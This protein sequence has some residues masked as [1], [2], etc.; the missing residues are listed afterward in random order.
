VRKPGR[1][2]LLALVLSVIGAWWW[3]RDDAPTGTA[4]SE[5]AERV[6]RVKR[7][8]PSGVRIR[9]EVLNGTGQRGLARRGTTA[10]RDAG[11]DVVSTGNWDTRVD[12]SL[13][14]VRTGNTEWGALAV[15]AFGAARLEAPPDSSRYVDLTIVLGTRW[16]PPPQPLDP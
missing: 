14:L 13:V 9:V 16:R 6:E 7:V 5:A 2:I 15:K 1:W 4:R 8:V 12:S 11:F 3:S 10:M